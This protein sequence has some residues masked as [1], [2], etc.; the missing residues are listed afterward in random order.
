MLP[1]FKRAAKAEAFVRL[2]AVR[3]WNRAA[4]EA[5]CD[6]RHWEWIDSEAMNG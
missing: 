3:Q 5:E 2:Q 1:V 6:G 4:A